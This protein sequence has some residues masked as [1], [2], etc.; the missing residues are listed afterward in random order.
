ML[1]SALEE[2]VAGDNVHFL[3][4]R[5]GESLPALRRAIVATAEPALGGSRESALLTNLRQ[6][7]AVI[8]AETHLLSARRAVESN[9]PHEMVLLELYASLQSLDELT[10]ATTNDDI[11]GKIFSTFCVGK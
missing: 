8:S 9:T 2:Y 4:A 11:L 10:G 1:R 6:Q 3:S 7:A 5:S